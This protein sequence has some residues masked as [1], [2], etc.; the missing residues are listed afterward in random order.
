M[1]GLPAFL[2]TVITSLCGL[3]GS[4][5][6]FPL[7]RWVGRRK[8]LLWGAVACGLC[9]LLFA[10]VGTARPDSTAAS[11]CLVVFVCL[12]LFTY[13]ATWGPL[14]MAVAS[15]VA[16]NG[17]RS[18]TMSMMNVCAYLTNLFI[19]CG[20][21]YLINEQYV[22]I[23]S[24]LGFIFGG[25]MVVG[26][27]WMFFELPETKDRTLEEI[28]EM[29]MNVSS[30]TAWAARPFL[31]RWT[32]LTRCSAFPPAPSRTTSARAPSWAAT[33]KSRSPKRRPRSPSRPSRSMKARREGP[34]IPYQTKD[35]GGE[36]GG[37]HSKMG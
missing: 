24:K 22:D 25:T 20:S 9:M 28:D 27:L 10:I 21:P 23:G 16:S 5:A 36:G 15:E 26:V 31:S 32:V 7:V 3:V 37:K 1:S 2:I 17:L 34:T 8:L 18:K 12:Y 33:K 4:A 13:G 11:T 29:F 6:A 35:K 14:P 30:G 19:D